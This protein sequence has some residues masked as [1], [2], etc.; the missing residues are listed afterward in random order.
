[1]SWTVICDSREIED[2]TFTS[3]EIQ[4]RDGKLDHGIEFVISGA[5][6]VAITPYTSISG[7]DWVS[8]GQK[9][10]G[11]GATSGPGSDGKQILPLLL[12]PSEF[13]KFDFVATGAVVL[14]SWFTQK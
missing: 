11:F 1:M 9:V 10:N 4:L 5:G 8:N 13:L 12:K 3:K 2:A 6:S 7:K 14:S